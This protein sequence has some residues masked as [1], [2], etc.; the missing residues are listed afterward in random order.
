MLPRTSRRVFSRT[1]LL[2]AASLLG[3]A[4]HGATLTWNGGLPGDW[5]TAN[6]NWS[7]ST[8]SNSNPDDAVF[9][10]IS[11]TITLTEAITAGSVSFNAGG[12][13]SGSHELIL[14]GGNLTASSVAVWG[15]YNPALGGGGVDSVTD[16]YNQRLAV[17]NMTLTVSGDAS[18]RRGMLFVNAATLN[19]GGAI[20]STDAWNV[21]RSDDSTVTATGGIDLSAIAS[22]VELYGGTVTTPFIRVSNYTNALGS[23]GLMMGSG[24]KVVATQANSDFIQVYNNSTTGSRAAATLTTGGVD[25]DTASYA[26]TITTALN[27]A[28]SLTKS[29]NGTLTLT[30][31]ISYTGGTIVN[32]GTLAL[33]DGDW[34]TGQPWNGTGATGAITI[35]AGATLSTSAGVTQFKSGLTLNGGT[36]S[37]RGL[38]YAGQWRNIVLSSDVT[39]GGGATST[40]ASAINLDGARTFTV[41]PASVLN[42]SGELA[43]WYSTGGSLTKSGNGTM[44]LSGANTYAGGTTINAGTLQVG[45][46]STTGTLGS[47]GVANSGSLVFNRSNDFTVGNAISGSGSL[48]KSGNGNLTLS[49]DSTYAGGTTISAGTLTISSQANAGGSSSLGNSAPTNVVTIGNGGVLTGS[50]YNWLDNTALAAGGANAHAVQVNAGGTLKGASGYITGLGNITLSGG[51]I[52]VSNGFANTDWNG[53]FTLGGDLTVSGASASAITTA[54]GAG[55]SANLQLSNGA[56]GVGGTRTFWVNDVTSSSASDLVVSARLANG[57]VVKEGAGT[58]ELAA[59]TGTGTSVDWTVNAG[60]I[61]LTGGRGVMKGAVTINTGG[62]VS[63]V[64][65]GDNRY[66]DVTSSR[67]N[68]GGLLTISGHSHLQNLTLAGGE[69]G[70]DGGNATYGTWYFDNATTVTGGVVSTI[71]AQDINLNNGN[72]AI[73]ANSTLNFTGSVKAGGFTLTLAA[74]GKFVNGAAANS[75]FSLGALT[76]NGGELAATST[77]AGNLGNYQLRGDITVGGSSMSTISADV[78]VVNNET[79]TFTVADVDGGAGVDLLLSGKIGHH[80]STAWGYANKAGAGTMKLSGVNEIGGLTVSAGLLILENT[81]IPGFGATGLTNNAA[82][83]FGVT[84]GSATAAY[85]ISGSG[86]LTKSGN[87]TLALTGNS[88]YGGSTTISGGTLNLGNGGSSGSLYSSSVSGGN[89]TFGSAGAIVNN[90]ALVYQFVG[91]DVR[92]NKTITGTGTLSV[93]GDRS[94]HFADGTSI[95]TTGAQTYSATAT[96]GRYYGFNLADNASVALTSSGAISMTGMLGTSNSNSGNLTLD[97]SAGNGNVTLNTAVGVSGVDFGMNSLTVLAGA[98]AVSLGTFNSQPWGTVNTISLTGGNVSSTAALTAFTSLTVTNTGTGTFSGALTASAGSLT[99]AG[100]GT[101]VLSAFNTYGG[102]TTVSAGTLTIDIQGTQTAS[103]VGVNKAVSVAAGATLRL[104]QTDGLG[105]WAANPSSLV[106]AGTMTIAAGKHASIGNFGMTLNGATLTAEGVGSSEGNYIFDG[107]VTSLANAA[108]SVISAPTIKLRNGSGAANQAVIFD[109]ADGAAATDLSVSSVLINGNGTNGLTKAGNGTLRLAAAN[110]YGGATT[111]NGGTLVLDAGGTYAYAGGNIAINGGSTLRVSG[112]AYTFNGKTIAFG[113]A[114]GGT[115]DAIATG[116]GGM[117]LT[118][119]NTITT[120]GGAQNTL[121]GTKL[122]GQNQG[123]NLNSQTL[124]FDVAVGADPAVPNLNVTGTLWNSGNLTKSGNGILLLSGNNEYS[125]TTTINAGTMIFRGASASSSHGI[126]TGAA[127]EFDVASG[128]RNL[129][130]ASFTGAGALRKTGAGEIA[131]GSGTATFALDSG[132]LIDVRAGTFTGGSHG[133]EN[134]TNNKAD[135]NVESGA[136]FNT[137]EANVRVNKITGAG[138]IKT[139]YDGSAGYQNL[140]IGIDN[141]SS[142]FAG[143]IANADATGNLV[144]AGTGAIMLS[145]TNT[146]SGSTTVNDGTLKV[147]TLGTTGG[148]SVGS[149][150]RSNTAN[151]ILNGAVTLE[152]AGAGESTSR[153]FTVSGTGLTLSSTGAGAVNFTVGSSIAFADSHANRE[154]KLSGTNTGANT[155]G[156]SLSGTPSDADKINRI[157]KDGVGTWILSGPANRFRNA[158]SIDVNAGTLGLESGAVGTSGFA[159]SIAVNAGATLR[160]EA[161]NTDDLSGRI[162][163]ADGVAAT[164][165]VSSGT[166]NFASGFQLGANKTGT[167]VKSGEGTLKLSASQEV[168]AISVNQGLLDVAAGTTVGSVNVAAGGTLS[169]KGTT[170]T[171]TVASRGIISPG[172]SPGVLT[173][174]SLTL[175]GGSIINW[176]VYDATGAAGVGYDRLVVTGN[177]DLTGASSSSRIILKISSINGQGLIDNPLN[178][179]APNGVSSIRTFQFGQVGGL[180]LPNGVQNI[181][182]LFTFNVDD[183]RYTD[184][185]ASNAGLWSISWNA[186]AITLTAVPEPSTYGLGLGALALAAAALRR[187][188]RQ[189]PKA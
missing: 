84:T 125:G 2:A 105:Y 120:S 180:L 49:G 86:T 39:A 97:T 87:G 26:V 6:T 62:T 89:L 36:L 42:V 32:G 70:G 78:R 174:S 163:I 69:L 29:G 138:T 109:V 11:G 140:T 172:S 83:E 178:F 173:H 131:W 104:A 20:T 41:G 27:G 66:W 157:I 13:P 164:V 55:A 151:L 14:T 107:T 95:T 46:G 145:G 135:L 100:N 168:S 73:E 23:T 47:G 142:T 179:A 111:I 121:S 183:F 152:Y 137:V 40:I 82:T 148:S 50:N 33:P 124:T 161:G 118:G 54:A 126:A 123:I 119:A 93:T 60:T 143:V 79:R 12:R 185:T 136:T 177:L 65:G 167:L 17:Q 81:A 24:V 101:L 21:F 59:A 182:D 67:V 52:E 80:N 112:L 10:N 175:S 106:I 102:G 187:R 91:G 19:V 122:S 108:S 51:T 117:Y 44:V 133:N 56:N 16:A 92:V 22:V 30:G 155:L 77:P 94:V 127:L 189:A 38:T 88:T 75:S 35:G 48:T 188:R 68:A 90:G 169:G 165:A 154:L 57:T 43:G 171:V 156:S 150:D 176:E 160:W 18:V 99:K 98:G 71:S 8:W 34:I 103:A 162:L 7:G 158:L 166:V 159:G 28:G 129:N 116:A 115:L 61:A 1:A 149:S 96:G 45:D 74:G 146:Y 186:G 134:W 132:A 113:A 4:S 181:S 114:G 64:A 3:A 170:G 58:L 15:G 153:S 144:K 53:S 128:S 37:S 141:G 110:S 25:F 147:T 31:S 85:A 139:G 130:T 63:S 184:G 5:N 9:N 76:L 72:F